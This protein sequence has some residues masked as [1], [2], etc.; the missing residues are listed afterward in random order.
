LSPSTEQEISLSSAQRKV[1][2]VSRLIQD[3]QRELEKGFGTLW[4]QG[5]LSN[6]SRPSSGHFYFTIKDSQAQIRCAMFKGRNR[7]V[8][9]EPKSG[10]AV[11]VRGKLGLYR[12][13][14]DFQLIVGVTDSL[15]SSF[16]PRQRK[17]Q[18]QH[19]ALL[20]QLRALTGARKP[21]CC[22]W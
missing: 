22:C 3:V 6:F 12:A 17:G 10:D 1:Y 9:F 8:D 11:T 7:Y 16:T 18:P 2:T 5:E 19:P 14:G 4:L 13:R 21:M 20:P 15:A